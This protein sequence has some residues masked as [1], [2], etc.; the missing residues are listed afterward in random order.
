MS[1]NQSSGS[2][3]R[4]YGVGRSLLCV[5]TLFVSCAGTIQAILMP[6]N[7]FYDLMRHGVHVPSGGLEVVSAR[8]GVVVGALVLVNLSWVIYGLFRW[9]SERSAPT[10]VG[11]A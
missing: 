5:L 6:L 2:P 7:I 3:N 10:P 11:T 9:R 4:G 1:R 8:I